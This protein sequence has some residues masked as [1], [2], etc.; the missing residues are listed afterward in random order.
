MDL[1]S[2]LGSEEGRLI[3][4]GVAAAGILGFVLQRLLWCLSA[5]GRPFQPQTVT[6][7]TKQTPAQVMGGCLRGILELAFWLSLIGAAALFLRR[8]LGQ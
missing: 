3:L 2:L 1:D 8:E 5:V 4:V 7:K 6:Q